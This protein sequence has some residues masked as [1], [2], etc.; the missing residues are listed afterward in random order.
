MFQTKHFDNGWFKYF[1]DIFEN[2]GSWLCRYVI[3]V[4]YLNEICSSYHVLIEQ[5]NYSYQDIVYL[6]KITLPKIET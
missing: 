2:Y 1:T 4:F 3:Q 5:I 6:D